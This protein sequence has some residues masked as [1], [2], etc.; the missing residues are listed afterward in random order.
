M[1]SRLLS[2]G[3]LSTTQ[4]QQ[5]DP[6]LHATNTDFP[7]VRQVLSDPTYRRMYVAHMKTIIEDVFESGWYE[8][9]ALEIQSVI[10]ADVQADPNTFYSYA[11]F[12]GNVDNTVTTGGGPGG[13]GPGGRSIVGI[14]QLMDARSSYLLAQPDFTAV[15][16]EVTA[17]STVPEPAPQ[18][19]QAVVPATVSGADAVTVAYRS[20]ASQAFTTV[21]MPDD[22]T[23]GD[24][25]AGDGVYGATVEVGAGDVEYYVYAE[26]DDAGA[27][28]PAGAAYET[29]LL[30]TGAG[31]VV[32][33]EFMADNETTATDQDG[34]FDDW[35]ELFNNTGAAVSLTG[36]GL[37][38]DADDLM[39]F[40]FPDTTLAAGG[41][42]IVWADG[43]TDQDGLHADFGLSRNGETLFL[44]L[45]DGVTI[46]D[47]VTFGAQDVDIS[48]GRD[49][50]GTG[51][52]VAMTPTFAA[53]NTGG[54]V[55]TEEAPDGPAA[56]SLRANFPNPFGTSTTIAFS[57]EQASHTTL[58]VY[59]AIGQRVATLVSEDLPSGDHS[60]SWAADGVASGLYFYRVQAGGSSQTRT[61]NVVR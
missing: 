30:E 11:N 34:E 27:F 8:T 20:S 10:D 48:T 29:Y 13:G 52:F 57:L 17:V 37:S 41:Y 1:F 28:S 55:G 6:F 61:M 14:T 45:P 32:I 15:A 50:N 40:V 3:N 4:M 38:D 18:F 24:G 19:S 33:N 47:E 44:T 43:D 42:L 5:L 53:E 54:T 46:T 7:I 16:P 49:P 25:G 35:I 51:D 23:Q 58:T 60:V 12:L 59:N 21:T 2:G 36:Y 56:L 22:G 39:Q 31:D 26:N 9:R